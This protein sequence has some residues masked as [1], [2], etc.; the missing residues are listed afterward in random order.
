MPSTRN[1]DSGS[2]LHQLL[3]SK[4]FRYRSARVFLGAIFLAYL[5]FFFIAQPVLPGRKQDAAHVSQDDLRS[6]VTMLSSNFY[7]RHCYNLPNL[8]ACAN[9]IADEFR[10]TKAE[11]SFQEYDIYDDTY[12]NVRAVFGDST[13]PRTVIVAHYDSCDNTPGADDNASGVAGL[14]ELAQLIDPATLKG[15]VE[16]VAVCTEEPPYFQTEHMGSAHHAKLMAR[17]EIDIKG[18]IA[19]EMIG[20]FSDKRFSQRFPVPLLYAFYPNR[21]NFITV[22]A[23]MGN[24]RLTRKVKRGMRSARTI[25]VLS[26]N[27]PRA[28]PGIEFSDH[29]NYWNEDMPAVMVTDTAFYRNSAYH[30]LEDTADRLDYDRMGAVVSAVHQAVLALDRD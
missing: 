23:D 6:H 19:L 9:Y 16:L 13:K 3:R 18:V 2:L 1:S 11:V 10:L 14:I 21:A 8:N 25:P 17:S 28:L 4:K 27:A 12:R 15:C 7:P 5:L 24:T 30:K 22:A 26:I 20:Y 29:L